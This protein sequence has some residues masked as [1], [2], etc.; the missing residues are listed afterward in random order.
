VT[1][2]ADFAA[3]V[4]EIVRER[5]PWNPSSVGLMTGTSFIVIA[6]HSGQSVRQRLKSIGN[7][8][9]DADAAI[10]VITVAEP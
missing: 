1:L 9:G 10:S 7:E 4:S 3:D 5:K 8:W 2:D 6:E